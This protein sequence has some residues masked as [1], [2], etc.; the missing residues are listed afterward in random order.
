[1]TA[2]PNILILLS[3]Q[4]R[5]DVMAHSGNPD[6]HTPHF[7]R[8]AA[9]GFCFSNTL[10]CHPLCAPFRATLQTGKYPFTHG[11]TFNDETIDYT[12]PNLA[13][14]FRNQN[15]ATA[16]FG[17]GHWDRKTK[18]GYLKPEERLNWEH[19]VGWNNGHEDYDMPTFDENDNPWLTEEPMAERPGHDQWGEFKH[20]YANLFAPGVQTSLLKDWVESLEPSKAWI[21]QVNWGPPHNI[22]NI[23]GFKDPETLALSKKIN[24]ELQ[25]GLSDVHFESYT[26][27]LTT[28]PQHLVSPM[29]PQHFLDLYDVDSIQVPENVPP[30]YHRLV[31]YQLKGYYAQVTALD[32]L[33]GRILAWLKET[34]RDKNTIVMYSSDHGDFLGSHANEAVVNRNGSGIRGKGSAHACNTRVPMIL[35]GPEYIQSGGSTQTPLGTVDLLPTLCGLAGFNCDPSMPGKNLADWG[36]HGKGCPDNPLLLTMRGWRGIYDGRHMYT[37]KKSGEGL[38]PFQLFDFEQDP[39]NLHNRIADPACETLRLHLH[40][41]LLTKMEGLSDPAVSEN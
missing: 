40:Q 1:M 9:E 15:Y 23:K 14:H 20:E 30:A 34:G 38:R 11:V 31:Q 19:W 2:K 39:L 17:K 6:V 10:S 7:D 27:W 8:M 26:A 25:L 4:H 36:L 35:W 32:D 24:K 29:V 5:A 41:L 12:L 28:F 37:L 3:D 13:G 33:T 21:A 18:P 22:S 16:F